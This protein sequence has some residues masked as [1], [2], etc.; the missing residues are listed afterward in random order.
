VWPLDL[1]PSSQHLWTRVVEGPY[2]RWWARTLY[3]RGIM[4]PILRSRAAGVATDHCGSDP[5][6]AFQPACR[7]VVALVISCLVP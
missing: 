3:E 1:S 5:Y 7:A 6:V 4:F 2:G